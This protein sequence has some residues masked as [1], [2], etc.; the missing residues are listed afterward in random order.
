MTTTPQHL[1]TSVAGKKGH[2][3]NKASSLDIVT[4][5]LEAD[6]T[7]QATLTLPLGAP[8]L[9]MPEIAQQAAADTM[10]SATPGEVAASASPTQSKPVDYWFSPVLAQSHALSCSWRLGAALYG[11]AYLSAFGLSLALTGLHPVGCRHQASDGGG[12]QPAAG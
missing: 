12:R 10:L 5:C 1:P 6:G 4:E 3:S 9:L 8:K 11:V 2:V 7:L